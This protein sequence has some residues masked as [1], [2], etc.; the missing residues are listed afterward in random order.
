LSTN[1]S[2]SQCCLHICREAVCRIPVRQFRRVA[3]GDD[4]CWFFCRG[5]VAQLYMYFITNTQQKR[6]FICISSYRHTN[7]RKAIIAT[8]PFLRVLQT[9]NQRDAKHSAAPREHIQIRTPLVIPDT[10]A[11]YHERGMANKFAFLTHSTQALYSS[12]CSS[13]DTLPQSYMYSSELLSRPR[14]AMGDSDGPISDFSQSDP[15]G[16]GK[17]LQSR[18]RKAYIPTSKSTWTSPETDQIP[19]KGKS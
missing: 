5:V 1:T 4:A 13:V 12:P 9:H 18:P 3:D 6:R 11:K 2:A 15:I 16:F 14:A 19:M 17:T 7:Q 10:P 8:L